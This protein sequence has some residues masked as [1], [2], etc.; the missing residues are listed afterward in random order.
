ML[1][2]SR[3]LPGLLLVRTELTLS[4]YKVRMIGCLSGVVSKVIRK[5]E[6]VD[7]DKINHIYTLGINDLWWNS[8]AVR[9]CSDSLLKTE[10]KKSKTLLKEEN[11]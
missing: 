6:M 2:V 1:S 3:S 7:L 8:I 9:E 11:R 5:T 4:Q 10:R